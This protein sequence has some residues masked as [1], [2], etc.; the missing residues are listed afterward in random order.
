MSEAY[1]APE[2]VKTHNGTGAFEN[3]SNG[4]SSVARLALRAEDSSEISKQANVLLGLVNELKSITDRACVAAFEEAEYADR[5]EATRDTATKSLREQLREKEQAVSDLQGRLADAETK[6]ASTEAELKAKEA[7][8]QAAATTQTEVGKLVQRL[9]TECNKL[10]AEL[11]EKRLII[12][13]FEKRE[14]RKGPGL[15]FGKL[16]GRMHDEDR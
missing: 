1:V 14:R 15:T 9:S 11:Q 5:I 16:L 8:I 13:Q 3:G 4:N 12:A 2:L 6:L 7:L 10:S